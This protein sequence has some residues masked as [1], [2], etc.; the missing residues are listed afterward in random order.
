[1]FDRAAL[2]SALADGGGLDLAALAVSHPSLFSAAAIALPAATL[3]AMR[4]LVAAIEAVVALPGYRSRVLAWAPTHADLASRAE[5]VLSLAP[6]CG[7]E[8]RGEGGATAAA[9]HPNP[10]PAGGERGSCARGVFLGYDFHL[11][12]GQPRL[13]EINTN[14]GG[15]MLNACLLRA[16]GAVDAADRVEADF[17]AMFREEWRLSR[18]DAPLKRIAIVDEQPEQQYLAPEFAL[19]RRLFERHGIAAVVAD[20]AEFT[21]SG[22]RLLYQGETVDLI[23]NRLTDFSLADPAHAE[24][25]AALAADG[26]VV[27]PHPFAHALYADKRNLMLLSDP[28][29]LDEFAVPP[30]ARAALLAGV[31]RTMLVRAEGGA[32]LL[33][34]G[35]KG[36]FFKP[37]AGFGSRAA[38]RGDKLTKRVFED[39]LQ[40]GYIAQEIAP[41]SE[42]V[43]SVEGEPQ[44]MKADFRAYV[45]QGRVQLF[46]A[47][48]Y[49]GQTTNFRTPGG[50]FAPVFAI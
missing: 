11:V 17:V 41:P 35:R 1:M 39:I 13:I 8:G 48:L 26:V 31:P 34:A 16:H 23:Y 12:D 15:G 19:F 21:R 7:G 27:T 20:P 47:R 45:Y 14:A 9:P 43:V 38:Y 30:A 18:G 6:A 42:H 4:D 25:R 37:A 36:W 49:Q 2:Q 32:Q 44:R 46:A 29:V 50:G 33:W 5:K 28:A 10:L 22:N 24:L 40:G 3:A